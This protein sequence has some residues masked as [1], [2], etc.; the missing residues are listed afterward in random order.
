MERFTLSELKKQAFEL[1]ATHYRHIFVAVSYYVNP[2][3]REVFSTHFFNSE[4]KEVG[5]YIDS[6]ELFRLCGLKTFS[7][8]RIWANEFKFNTLTNPAIRIEYI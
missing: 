7:S 8:P 4:D 6:C 5:Y 2:S 3:R 1:G